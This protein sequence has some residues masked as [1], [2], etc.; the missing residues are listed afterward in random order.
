MRGDKIPLITQYTITK[1]G[2]K[3]KRV[4]Q[5]TLT[6]TEEMKA[7]QDALGESASMWYGT[8]CDKCCGVYPAFMNEQ[9]FNN[10]GYYV[11]L[12]CGKESKHMPMP[13]QARDEW[14]AGNFIFNPQEDG[15]QLTIFDWLGEKS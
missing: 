7:K 14:N 11:C 10:D 15:C 6:T 4:P 2:T 3:S 1:N 12:V 9:T 13:W 5:Y 8:W